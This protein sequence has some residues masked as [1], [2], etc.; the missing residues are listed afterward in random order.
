MA[1]YVNAALDLQVDAVAAAATYISAHTADPSTNG[2]NE[3]T[4]GSYARQQTT[5]GAKSGAGPRTRTGSQ[6]TVPIPAGTTVTHWGLWSAAS[7]GT[8]YGSFDINPDETF[9]SAGNLLVTP[10]ISSSAT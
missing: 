4:G 1:G 5:W 3:V 7:A 9:G 6:V 10:T 2:A 8:F